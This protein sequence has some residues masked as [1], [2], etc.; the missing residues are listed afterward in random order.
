MVSQYAESGRATDPGN[1]SPCCGKPP[2]GEPLP[3]RYSTTIEFALIDKHVQPLAAHTGRG[4][5]LTDRRRDFYRT[6]RTPPFDTSCGTKPERAATSPATPTRLP[7]S[8]RRSSWPTGRWPSAKQ[9]RSST[10]G[11][12]R[13]TVAASTAGRYP[14]VPAGA[15]PALRTADRD[16]TTH[17]GPPGS[18]PHRG[19]GPAVA[20]GRDVLTGDGQVFAGGD[21]ARMVSTDPRHHDSWAGDPL[22]V[23]LERFH[24][25]DIA[26]PKREH[27]TDLDIAGLFRH[28][29]LS[30]HSYALECEVTRHRAAGSAPELRRSQG[31]AFH[32]A[33]RN[34]LFNLPNR[35][36]PG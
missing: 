5:T 12:G 20:G 2:C 14:K 11:S 7:T 15:A 4:Y 8:S 9:R 21:G 18:W 24:G 29:L 1:C 19:A 35:P 23:P 30:L 27:V 26:G 22:R 31:S 16:P 28:H 13:V 33:G 34:G 32:A 17:D 10:R 25:P 6:K 36:E 3:W